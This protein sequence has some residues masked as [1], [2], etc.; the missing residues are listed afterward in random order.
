MLAVAVQTEKPCSVASDNNSSNRR[1]NPL[2]REG[3]W[4]KRLF[5]HEMLTGIGGGDGNVR[6]RFR[7]HC[8]ADCIDCI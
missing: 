8:H 5:Q 3:V 1:H 2:C 6:L 7:L 4:G